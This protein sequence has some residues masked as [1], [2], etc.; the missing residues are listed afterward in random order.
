MNLLA[1]Q[2][3]WFNPLE[4]HLQKMHLE[5]AVPTTH[6]HP[7][8][9]LEARSIIGIEE[10]K[11]LNHLGFLHLPQRVCWRVMGVHYQQ[12]PQCHSDMTGQMGQDIPDEVDDIEKK[13]A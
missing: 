3:F 11:G 12:C 4:V 13:P 5:I 1:Q 6:C 9:P 10:T 2:S 8:G 7:I